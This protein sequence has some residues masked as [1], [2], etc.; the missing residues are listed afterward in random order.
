[1]VRQAASWAATHGGPEALEPLSRH[2][3]K[4]RKRE[5]LET[6]LANLWRLDDEPWQVL[7]AS[8]ANSDEVFLRRAAGAAPPKG[9]R[10]S[11]TRDA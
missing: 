8:Y 6:L 5:V 9:N 7:A 1:M 4:E 10:R 3:A 11:E 2:L